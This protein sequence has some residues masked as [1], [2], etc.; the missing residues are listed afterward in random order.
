M[1]NKNTGQSRL[2]LGPIVWMPVVLT[3]GSDG[4]QLDSFAG[5][6]VQGFVHV[7]DLVDP[8]LASLGLL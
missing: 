1:I 2:Q 3:L 7:V 4:D 5:D 6:E 8:H